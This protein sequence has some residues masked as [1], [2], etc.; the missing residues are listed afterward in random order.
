MQR[1]YSIIRLT[2]GRIT[3]A[4]PTITCFPYIRRSVTTTTTQRRDAL[5]IL[6]RQHLL[7]QQKRYVHANENTLVPHVLP[8]K[9]S[10]LKLRCKYIHI[11]S[12]NIIRFL[13]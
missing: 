10:D 4:Q 13:I 7:Q 12:L 9:S 3:I 1:L 5:F 8:T 6:P 11:V 2:P